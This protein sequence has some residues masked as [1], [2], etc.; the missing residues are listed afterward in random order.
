MQGSQL[1]ILF[2]CKPIREQNKIKKRDILRKREIFK[3]IREYIKKYGA[4]TG[5]I[6]AHNKILYI[7]WLALGYGEC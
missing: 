6:L 4:F 1:G 2:I 3:D 7:Q 5:C